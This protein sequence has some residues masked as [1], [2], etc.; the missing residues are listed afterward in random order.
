MKYEGMFFQLDL[1]SPRASYSFRPWY[2]RM[3]VCT[4]INIGWESQ[5]L[6]PAMKEATERV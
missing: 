3:S 2:N 4:T 1:V 5:T 6:L